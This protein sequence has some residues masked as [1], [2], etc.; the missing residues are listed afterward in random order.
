MNIFTLLK[1][2]ELET[3]DVKS[4]WEEENYEALYDQYAEVIEELLFL[5]NKKSFRTF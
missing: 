1:S 3:A 2:K 4:L 5:T